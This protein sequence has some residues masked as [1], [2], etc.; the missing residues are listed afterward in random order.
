MLCSSR[1][2]HREAKSLLDFNT[3]LFKT[4][5]LDKM[6]FSLYRDGKRSKE[7][8]RAPVTCALIGGFKE[9][10]SCLR[11]KVSWF[12]FILSFASRRER[13]GGLVN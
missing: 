6:T 5:S 10:S 13:I 12:F 3:G 1:L 8:D 9:A 7:C 11:G 2:V 4:D